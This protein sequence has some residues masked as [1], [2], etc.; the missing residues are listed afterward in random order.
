[1]QESS[2]APNANWNVLKPLFT[3][4]LKQKA[5]DSP[6]EVVSDVVE[7]QELLGCIVSL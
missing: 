2:L 6:S 1:M 4:V 3:K 7:A 5:F